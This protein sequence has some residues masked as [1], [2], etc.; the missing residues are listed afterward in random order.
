QFETFFAVEL[1]QDADHQLV[2][3]GAAEM[4]PIGALGSPERRPDMADQRVER[5]LRAAT[6][7][8]TVDVRMLVDALAR[9]LQQS[10]PIH[11]FECYLK[12]DGIELRLDQLVHRQG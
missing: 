10:V 6:D 12:P 8:D 5:V 4:A 7:I 2:D 11:R 3:L 1:A 9:D